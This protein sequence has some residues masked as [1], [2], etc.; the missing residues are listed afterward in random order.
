M[1]TVNA[2][3][4]SAIT[5]KKMANPSI[6]SNPREAV[7]STPTNEDS[8]AAV[9]ASVAS[10][11]PSNTLS[12]RGTMTDSSSTSSAPPVSTSSGRM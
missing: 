11:M 6:A 10:V 4:N 7:A 8:A 12:R 1:S 9:A 2:A 3:D 5:L